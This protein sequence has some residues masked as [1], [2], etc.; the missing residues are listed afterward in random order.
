LLKDIRKKKM[1]VTKNETKKKREKKIGWA[2][3]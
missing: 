3:I 2:F 1:K